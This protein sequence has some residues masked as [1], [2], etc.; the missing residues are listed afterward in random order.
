MATKRIPLSLE[1][2]NF[3]REKIN[4]EH[5]VSFLEAE[6]AFNGFRGR[7]LVDD[8]EKNFAGAGR[9]TVWCLSQTY[10]GRLLKLVIIPDYSRNRCILRTAYEPNHYEVDLWNKN[11]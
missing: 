1:A 4:S 6:E 7:F 8:R 11:Q 10:D 3:V 2:S 9:R 5:G